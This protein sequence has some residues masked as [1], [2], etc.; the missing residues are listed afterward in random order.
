M[1]IY[2]K[3][4]KI[5]NPTDV[6]LTANKR[7]IPFLHKAYARYQQ[8]Q[9]KQLWP[10]PLLLTLSD[11][12]ALHWEK[13]LFTQSNI[14][15]SLL[16]KPQEL[17]L[18]QTIINKSC[19]SSLDAI[20]TAKTAQQAWQL[21]QQAKLDYN[22]PLFKQNSE[23]ETWQNWANTFVDHCKTIRYCDLDSATYVLTELFQKKK[24]NPPKRLFLF[25]FTELNPQT[26]QLLHCLEQR[27][28]KVI[29]YQA[30]YNNTQCQRLALMDK[31]TE[32][33]TMA[34]WAYQCW[35]DGKQSIA[36]IVP[37]L[38]QQRSQLLDNFTEVFQQLAGKTLNPPPFNI[39]A[40]NSLKEFPLMQTALRIIELTSINPFHKI[41]EL[42]RSPYLGGFQHEQSLRA[43][44]DVQ[45]RCHAESSISWEQLLTASK[46]CACSSLSRSIEQFNCVLNEYEPTCLAMP[47]HWATHFAKKLQSFAWPGDRRLSSSEFQLVERWSECLHE[48]AGFDFILGPIN[49]TAAHQQLQTLTSTWL[50]QNKTINDPPIQVLGLLDSAGICFDAL[51]IMGLDD[52]TL[53]APAKPNPFIPYTLQRQHQLPH[54]TNERELYFASLLMQN[55][56]SS[57]PQLI[58]S[59]SQQS[60]DQILRPS[61]LIRDIPEI[62]CDALKLPFYPS[63]DERLSTQPAWEYYNDE[64]GPALKDNEEFVTGSQLFQSQAACPFQAFARFRLA[65]HFYPFPKIGLNARERGKLIHLV[66][67]KFW[68]SIIQHTTLLQLTPFA[69]DQHIDTAIDACLNA[70]QKKQPIIFKTHF[71]RIER[72]RLQ[73]MLKKLIELEKR[74]PLFLQSQHEQ[75]KSYRLGPLSLNLRIDRIDQLSDSNHLIIDYKTSAPA[76][77]DWLAERLDYP[78]LPLYCLAYSE[79]VRGFALLHIRSNGISLQ[80]ISVDESVMPHLDSLKKL[81]ASPTLTW[82]DLLQHWKKQLE[83]LA[84]QFQTG[85]ATVDPK[86]NLSTCRY[87]DLQLLCRVKHKTD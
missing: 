1:E 72:Q 76:N 24:L 40:G 10:T 68:N 47:S 79:T 53:P 70:M 35:Q 29:H 5:L 39:A 66:L 62:S 50:F 51:W 31:Q 85:I 57:A 78:Q 17:V 71:M 34:R 28:C 80:G 65:A 42:I 60:L 23:T 4:F 75:K 81:T 61:V 73:A 44:L 45:L 22:S 16:S 59:H 25:G 15:M 12:L 20:H 13:Q 36:C 54:A 2:N 83:K 21:L 41:S 77:I 3:L 87:C 30:N 56:L 69:I 86:R 9:K 26:K 49:Q 55:L 82:P 64:Q 14:G 11:W 52:R 48:L 33:T 8:T 27:H 67:E 46:K 84:Q 58:I 74:R 7:L 63:L 43:Q 6:L 19:Y 32:Y 37:N 38:I 18:W